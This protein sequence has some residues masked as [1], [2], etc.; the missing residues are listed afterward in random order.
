MGGPKIAITTATAAAPAAISPGTAKFEDAGMVNGLPAT[1]TGRV[2]V[3]TSPTPAAVPRLPAAVAEPPVVPVAPE[4]PEPL[5]FEPEPELA[6]ETSEAPPV[7]VAH[8]AEPCLSQ[9]W[10]WGAVVASLFEPS[11]EKVGLLHLPMLT[12]LGSPPGILST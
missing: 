3:V 7:P 8:C 4:E 9:A 11:E 1:V 10:G 12:F 2:S 5:D 6:V